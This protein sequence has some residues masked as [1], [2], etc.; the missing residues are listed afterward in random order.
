MFWTDDDS[1]L[2]ID[3]LEN[4]KKKNQG[5]KSSNHIIDRKVFSKNSQWFNWQFVPFMIDKQLAVVN[6]NLSTLF[7]LSKIY[8]LN[9]KFNFN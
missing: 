7:F 2:F 4:F 5:A 9:R 8:S 1:I 3:T 6:V